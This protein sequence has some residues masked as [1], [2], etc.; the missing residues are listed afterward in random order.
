MPLVS[1]IVPVFNR[2]ELLR[3]TVASLRSQTLEDAEF[4]IVDD[5]SDFPAA[6][7]V[8]KLAAM[9]SRFKVIRK[10]E[11]IARGSQ[12]SRNV[13]LEA[14]TSEAVVF[15]DSD[16]LLA[17]DCLKE[18]L[19]FLRESPE[20]D[21]VVGRQAI[22]DRDPHSLVWVNTDDP[23]SAAIDRFL[24]LGGPLDVPWVNAGVMI[25][26]AALIDKEIR[27]RPEFDWD[28]VAFHFECLVAGMNVSW[29]SRSGEP[30][31][32]YRK[33]N[34]D[35]FGS[36][37]FKPD[38]MRSTVRMLAWM[39]SLL[40]HSDQLTASRDQSLT[41]S[42]FYTC[43]LRALD[44]N[45][46]PLAREL[47]TE[48]ATAGLIDGGSGRAM[49]TYAAGRSFVRASGRVTYYWNRLARRAFLSECYSDRNSTYAT[50][51]VAEGTS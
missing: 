14:A 46:F 35:R 27:W 51:K 11:A 42:F 50:I 21:I 48:A 19:A 7:Y 36:A 4:V 22:M 15:L 30:D 33:H 3:D 39:R 9:D 25:R 20:T 43:A 13:G 40:V 45:N 28:D 10:P 23:G 24:H 18:R 17:P 38:G 44:M 8:S 47:I 41:R 12:L 6:D 37:L 32:F 26:R 34:S 29:M 1:V 16:D 49:R 31:A 2:L 5:R